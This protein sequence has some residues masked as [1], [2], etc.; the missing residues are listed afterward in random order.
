MARNKHV[1][2]SVGVWLW[3]WLWLFQKLAP[4]SGLVLNDQIFDSGSA[5]FTLGSPKWSWASPKEDHQ[6][7]WVQQQSAQPKEWPLGR[8]GWQDVDWRIQDHLSK[9]YISLSKETK[10]F[11]QAHFIQRIVNTTITHHT[12]PLYNIR[13]AICSSGYNLWPFALD[14]WLTVWS[15]EPNRHPFILP[16]IS[17]KD[18]GRPATPRPTMF[19]I[20]EPFDN[21]FTFPAKHALF[22]KQQNELNKCCKNSWRNHVITICLVV[23][24][25]FPKIPAFLRIYFRKIIR[26]SCNANR[27]YTNK[28]DGARLPVASRERSQRLFKVSCNGV[29]CHQSGQLPPTPPKIKINM[30]PE[31]ELFQKEQYVQPSFFRGHV[32]FWGE[33]QLDIR[34]MNQCSEDTNECKDSVFSALG[35]GKIK[36]ARH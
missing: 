25:G 20:H 28:T 13:S 2:H 21:H 8:W 24:H 29:F 14:T 9:R 15:T 32:G 23:F 6:S 11:F 7:W 26:S 35:L 31:K 33:Y 4:L 30:S 17:A 22:S 18:F 19:G 5:T 10:N 27:S 12:L 3:L 1:L 34:L 36:F 16:L